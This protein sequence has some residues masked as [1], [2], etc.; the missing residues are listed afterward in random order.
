MLL[1]S[2]VWVAALIRRAQLGG[3]FATLVRKGDARAGAVLVRTLDGRGG[4]ARLYAAATGG[5]GEPLWMQPRP[6]A[7]E[8]EL[9]AYCQR[10]ARID[11]DI[12]IVEIEDPDGARFLTEAVEKS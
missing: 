5:A 1:A 7:H 8:D 2:E 3:A 9:D 10:A 11:P 12:W 4:R 6:G